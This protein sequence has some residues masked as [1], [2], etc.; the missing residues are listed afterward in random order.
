M[1]VNAWIIFVYIDNNLDIIGKHLEN[2]H[3]HLG[4]WAELLFV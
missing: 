3:K 2:W 1:L 4:M